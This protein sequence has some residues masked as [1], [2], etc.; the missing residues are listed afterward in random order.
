MDTQ[1]EYTV[2][3]HSNTLGTTSTYKC[4]SIAAVRKH[5]TQI[6]RLMGF[7]LTYPQ[8]NQ[9][10][11]KNLSTMTFHLTKNLPGMDD[12]LTDTLHV[13]T[14]TKETQVA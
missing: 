13:T 6:A 3:T 12:N 4:T 8:I 11:H 10:A 9:Q 5:I 7:T 1:K 2:R 14:T